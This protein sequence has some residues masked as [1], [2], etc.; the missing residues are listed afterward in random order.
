MTKTLPKG[1]LSIL[2][3]RFIYRHGADVAATFARVREKMGKPTKVRVGEIHGIVVPLKK[4]N[5]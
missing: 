1:H 3:K 4:A 5:Q 2:D